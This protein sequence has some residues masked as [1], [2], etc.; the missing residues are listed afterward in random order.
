MTI[1]LA[2]FYDVASA[3][4]VPPL[5]GPAVRSTTEQ[6]TEVT[7]DSLARLRLKMCVPANSGVTKKHCLT[8]KQW[9]P[10]C[11]TSRLPPPACCA[12][13]SIAQRTKKFVR[14]RGRGRGCS[15]RT[16][17]KN[18]STAW[19]AATHWDDSGACRENWRCSRD[20]H[21]RPW[22]HSAGPT[23]LPIDLRYGHAKLI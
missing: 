17:Q 12:A 14:R 18:A 21:P 10:E 13:R 7:P 23:R 15:R 9:H 2:G 16:G 5:A 3:S 22:R 4:C 11:L 6:A 20:C 19:A 8:S 1:G